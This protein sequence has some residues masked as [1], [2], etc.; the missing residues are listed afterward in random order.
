MTAVGESMVEK[1]VITQAQ[2]AQR[3][4]VIPIAISDGIA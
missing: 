1:R 4:K 2:A 3:S